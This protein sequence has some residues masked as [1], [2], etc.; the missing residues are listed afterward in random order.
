MGVALVGVLTAGT[1]VGKMIEKLS[2][3]PTVGMGR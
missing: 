2:P 1:L 3:E